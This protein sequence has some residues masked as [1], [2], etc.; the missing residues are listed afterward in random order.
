VFAEHDSV[1]DCYERGDY[2]AQCWDGQRYVCPVCRSERLSYGD[3]PSMA[4]GTETWS[5]CEA[6]GWCAGFDPTGGVWVHMPKP[7]SAR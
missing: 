5:R 1:A 7:E 2:C 3:Q 4:S 6:C